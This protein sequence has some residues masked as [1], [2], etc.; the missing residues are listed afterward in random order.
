MWHA[1]MGNWHTQILMTTNLGFSH[2]VAS[3]LPNSNPILA[4]CFRVINLICQFK[5]WESKP[6]PCKPCSWPGPVSCSS[7]RYLPS[8]QYVVLGHC[9]SLNNTT[10]YSWQSRA[11]TQ[12]TSRLT[13]QIFIS[14][15]KW[16]LLT[17]F[18]VWL[19]TGVVFICSNSNCF[20]C[21]QPVSQ[22]HQFWLQVRTPSQRDHV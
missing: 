8:T 5:P 3:I 20:C 11:K 21:Q 1:V 10:K 6:A 14:K 15:A 19:L 13:N 9:F 22:Q 4:W 18:A 16:K 12:A 2:F 7:F 17:I